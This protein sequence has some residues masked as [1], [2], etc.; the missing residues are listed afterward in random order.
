MLLLEI[1]GLCVGI[2]LLC[3]AII[4]GNAAIRLFAAFVGITLAFG[5][6]NALDTSW[7]RLKNYDQYIYHFAQYSRHPRGLAERQELAELTNNVILFD[8]KFG[9]RQDARDLEDVVFQ[10]LKVGSYYQEETNNVSSPQATNSLEPV[11]K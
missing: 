9:A 10:I 11:R 6:G 7:E 5:V 2:C 1:L 8:T 4:H 3:R